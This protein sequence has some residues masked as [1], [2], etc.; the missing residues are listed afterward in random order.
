[1]TFSH[2]SR[3]GE[4]LPINQAKVPLEDV[5]YSY[6]FGV[7]ETVRVSAG[8]PYFL[9][10]HCQRLIDSA[11]IIGLEHAFTAE[12]VGQFAGDLLAKLNPEA[13]NLKIL[14]IGGPTPE[15]ACLYMLCL[16][17]LFPDRKLYKTGAHCITA[18]YERPFPHA[19]TLNMLPSYLAFREAKAAGAYDALLV[20]RTGCLVEGTRTNFL[21]LQGKTILS[22][23]ETD[24]L[25]GVT[26]D[27]VLAVAKQHGFTV[28]ETNIKLADLS[29][30]DGAFL[31][32]T[33]SKIMP[34]R[35]IGDHAW[36]AL[37]PAIHELI[38]AFNG[39]LEDYAV[40]S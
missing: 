40:S 18:N 32:S 38:T 31:T 14:L 19:K 3:N 15:K 12:L 22:P 11:A 24:I 23:P 13:C 26:R 8:R 16:N 5:E 29:R 17:P 9:A 36:P 6:G 21:V 2:F 1:M 20:N 39:Y 4:V 35:S 37:P 25:L 33:S 10:E 27:K 7:Y 28:M 30:Y 34:L